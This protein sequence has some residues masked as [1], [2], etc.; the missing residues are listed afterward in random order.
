MLGVPLNAK[1]GSSGT[2][3]LRNAAI[4]TLDMLPE[5]LVLVRGLGL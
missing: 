4:G 5:L 1:G 2:V 3:L